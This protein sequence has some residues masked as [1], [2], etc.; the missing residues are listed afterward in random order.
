MA[1][2]S[3]STAASAMV[4]LPPQAR[5]AGKFIG[6]SGRRHPRQAECRGQAAEGAT[7]QSYEVLNSV[8]RPE[9]SVFST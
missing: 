8:R 1:G 5:S 7:D 6:H 4:S 3:S 2:Y 9:S